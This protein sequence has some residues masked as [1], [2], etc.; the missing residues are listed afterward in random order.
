VADAAGLADE[1]VGGSQRVV[2]LMGVVLLA[3]VGGA[4]SAAPAASA[5]PTRAASRST[6]LRAGS[7]LSSGDSTPSRSLVPRVRAWAALSAQALFICHSARSSLPRMRARVR[8][9]N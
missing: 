6:S 3:A 8:L 7:T 4:G 1:Q 5:G 2:K 9:M